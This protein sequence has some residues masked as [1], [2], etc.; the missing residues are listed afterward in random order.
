QDDPNHVVFSLQTTNIY[1]TANPIAATIELQYG[2][3]FYKAILINSTNADDIVW[4]PFDSTNVT[5]SLSNGL[6]SVYV[7]VRGRQP[8][9]WQSWQLVQLTLNTNP[10]TL[11]VTNPFTNVVS[12]PMIQLQGY[13][14]KP[15]ASLT[16]DISNAAGIFTNRTGYINGQFYDTNLQMFT[17]NY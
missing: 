5:F 14:S 17:V 11:T 1:F 7:G 12:Q 6:S 15:L 9:S 2:V 13:G 8:E 16:Y 3:P 10:L 4:E